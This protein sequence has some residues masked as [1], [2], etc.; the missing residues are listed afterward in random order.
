MSQP[1]LRRFALCAGLLLAPGCYSYVPTDMSLVPQGEHLRLLVT[2][3]GSQ[4]VAR[5]MD[6]NELRPTVRGQFM[7]RDDQSLLL[8]VPVSRDPEGIRQ[9]INQVVRIPEGEVLTVDRRQFSKGK[10]ALVVGG[11]VAA[12]AFLLTQIFDVFNDSSDPGTDPDLYI[13]LF[14]VPIG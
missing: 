7:G 14:G 6:S 9:N 10:T 2:R 5:I 1:A 13:G 12:G 11:A 4:E 3:E 8:Q